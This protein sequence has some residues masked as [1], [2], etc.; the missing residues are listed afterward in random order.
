MYALQ[1]K[2][3][4]QIANNDRTNEGD[5]EEGRRRALPKQETPRR[6]EEEELN[7]T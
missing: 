5:E 2:V 1:D 7:K 4:I 6:V 3:Y